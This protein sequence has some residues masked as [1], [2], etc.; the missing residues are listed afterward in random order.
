MNAQ[1]QVTSEVLST[2]VVM[3]EFGRDSAERTVELSPRDAEAVDRE[4]AAGKHQT[5][6]DALAYVISR[7]L[8][9][10][11]RQR[12]AA[13]AARQKSVLKTTRDLY[14]NMLKLNPALVA[15]PQFVQKMVADLGMKS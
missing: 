8:A 13:E 2:D 3:D 6:D 5:Y 10:I 14:Q 1:A 12:D 15:D 7:G 9:E 4:V 11:K